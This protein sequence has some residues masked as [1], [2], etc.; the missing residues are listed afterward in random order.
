LT[1]YEP[2]L[3]SYQI[4]TTGA[5]EYCA[6]VENPRKVDLVERN[7]ES[8]QKALKERE[9]RHGATVEQMTIEVNNAK[10]VLDNA[11]AD[12]KSLSNL[13]NVRLLTSR[14]PITDAV[15]RP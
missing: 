3:T 4:W 5:E 1:V 2:P 8:V 11:E 13:N 10:A 7:L 9:R 15:C 12:M 14:S 6:R